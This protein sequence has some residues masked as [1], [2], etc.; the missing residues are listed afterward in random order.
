M[1]FIPLEEIKGKS[2]N[3]VLAF[4]QKNEEICVQLISNLQKNIKNCFVLYLDPDSRKEIYGIVSLKS[5]IL[6]CLPFSN[7]QTETALQ[8]DFITS[9]AIFFKEN[10]FDKPVCLNGTYAGSQLILKALEKLSL[11]PAESNSY[12]LLKLDSK[13][14]VK[15]IVRNHRINRDLS[16]LRCKKDLPAPLFAQLLNLQIKYELEE[17]LP[18][19]M[20]FDEDSCRLRLLN[21]LRKQYVLALSTI[22]QEGRE[23]LIAKAGTNSIGYKHV[24]I[25][26]VFT[27]P[28]ER[29]KHYAFYLLTLL[30]SKIVKMKR[31]PV[32]FVKKQN[33]PAS[34]LYDSLCFEKITDYTIAYFD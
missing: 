24:Q 13:S 18:S 7:P 30:L 11:F 17:V 26:G 32:L 19:C 31:I 23:T 6:H 2:R 12:S 15:K 8:L 4:L 21:A 3:S 28:E 33:S 22:N 5:T 20:E 1:Y 10:G 9:F 34:K 25:G 29:G 16:V 27:L 14:F